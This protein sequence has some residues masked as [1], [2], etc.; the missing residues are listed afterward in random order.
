MQKGLHVGEINTSE[1]MISKKQEISGI[2][3]FL[4]F[5]NV[6]AK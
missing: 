1:R 5:G 2:G 4:N 6:S 3:A